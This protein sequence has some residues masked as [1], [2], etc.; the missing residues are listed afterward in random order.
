MSIQGAGGVVVKNNTFGVAENA[1]NK[2]YNGV[3]LAQ[4]SARAT[5][6]SNT[7]NFSVP[8]DNHERRTVNIEGNPTI[9]N[10]AITNNKLN[11]TGAVSP[12]GVVMLLSA[13]GNTASGYGVTNL[14]VT[15]NTV[16]A[17]AESKGSA[18]GAYYRACR[19]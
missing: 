1:A 19:T 3:F 12:K 10:V 9:D 2:T 8:Q 5:I 6:D 17:A 11:V 7:F 13:F 15:G 18:Y 4:G 16:T 14:T